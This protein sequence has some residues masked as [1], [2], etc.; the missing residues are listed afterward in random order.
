MASFTAAGT[1]HATHGVAMVP[2]YIF[3]SMFGYQRVGDLAWAFGD[4]RGRG[5]VMGATAGRTTLNGEGLQH[6]DGHSHVMFANVPNVRCYDPAFAF[7]IATIVA[8]G[9][10]RM[11]VDGEDVFYYI[12]LQN[13]NYMMPAEPANVKEGILKGLYPFKKAEKRQQRHVQLFGSGSIMQQVLSAQEK[14][15]TLGVSADVWGAPSYQL[16]R[17]D[18]LA[19]ERWNRLHPEALQRVPYLHKAL[20]G[21][22]GPFI[23]ASDWVKAWPDMIGRWVPG[24]YVV[25]GT[26]GYG[27]SDTRPAL[28]RHFEVDSENIALAALDALRLDGKMTGK[29][30]TNALKSLGIDPEKRDPMGV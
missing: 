3:Y 26:D 18:I 10:K 28:R 14:L 11:T 24:R 7:E 30:V 8:D 19:C 20:R 23:A 22:E 13:E 29:D 16:L 2:F 25:L 15:A 4:Q 12:T 6:Q 9:M 5:F 27:M 1:S 17:N 21:V